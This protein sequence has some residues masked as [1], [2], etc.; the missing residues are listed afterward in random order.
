MLAVFVSVRLP[1]T[2]SGDD[3][4]DD[5]SKVVSAQEKIQFMI[6]EPEPA[7]GGI[8]TGTRDVIVRVIVA[9]APAAAP[10]PVVPFAITIQTGP[11]PVIDRIVPHHEVVSP[12]E[13]S[14]VENGTYGFG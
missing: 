4:A 2:K 6:S 5:W 14:T 8:V 13:A 10:L 1:C 7:Y 11:R 12:V 9:P 3:S